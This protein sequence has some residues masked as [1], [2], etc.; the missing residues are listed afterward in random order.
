MRPDNRTR[1]PRLLSSLLVI[2]SILLLLVPTL[3]SKTI[4]HPATAQSGDSSPV[5]LPPPSLPPPPVPAAE[6]DFTYA[7]ERVVPEADRVEPIKL[8]AA[9]ELPAD[10]VERLLKRLPPFQQDDKPPAFTFPE[11]TLVK[12][13][14]SGKTIEEKFPPLEAPPKRKP[15][16]QSSAL[17]VLRVSQ[18]GAIDTAREFAITFSQPM[19]PVSDLD[20]VNAPEKLPVKFSPPTNGTWRWAGCQTLVFRPDNARKRFA[21]ATAYSVEIPKGT[22][23]AVGGVLEKTA[24]FSFTTAP[25]CLS[26]F[27]PNDGYQPHRLDQTMVL[28]FNQDIDQKEILKFINVTTSSG[29]GKAV[30]SRGSASQRSN[31]VLGK[32]KEGSAGDSSTL[33]EL[34]PVTEEI[35][36]KDDQIRSFIDSVKPSQWIAVKARKAFPIQSTVK[37][38]LLANCPSAEGPLK[39][40]SA[41]NFTFKTYGP[42]K[43]ISGPSKNVPADYAESKTFSFS[44]RIDKDKFKPSLVHVSPRIEDMKVVLYDYAPAIY[45]QGNTAIN[46]RYSV[47]FDKSICDVFGQQLGKDVVY[48]F[49]TGAMNPWLDVPEKPFMAIPA[50][51]P[52]EFS[53]N[54]AGIPKVQVKI[55]SV[56]PEDW[57]QF[58]PHTQS[59]NYYNF[60]SKA[61]DIGK[62]CQSKIIPVGPGQALIKLD[63]KPY[64]KDGTGQFVVSAKS[65]GTTR[66]DQRGFSEWVQVSNIGI[67]AYRG[68]KL[69]LMASSLGNG[70]PLKDARATV[71]PKGKS[72]LTDASGIASVDLDEQEKN[73]QALVVR[74]GTDC[75]ILPANLEWQPGWSALSKSPQLEWFAVTDR[76]LYRPGQTVKVKG[77][78]RGMQLGP[79]EQLQIFKSGADKLS[80]KVQASDSNE[81]K[82]GDAQLDDAGGFTF[83][84]DL[85]DH[86]SL[87]TATIQLCAQSAGARKFG[88]SSTMQTLEKYYNNL[89]T[90]Q[91]NFSVQEY[92]RP[93]FEMHL[94]SSSG[95]TLMLGEKT[96]IVADAKYFAGD[97]LQNAAISWVVQPSSTCYS[98]PGWSDFT[99]GDSPSWFLSCCSSFPGPPSLLSS[100]MAKQ[101]SGTTDASGKDS[102]DLRFISNKRHTPITCQCEATVTDV[103]RQ[104]WSDKLTLLVH[105]ASV[106]VGLKTSR[107]FYRKGEPISVDFVVTDLDGKAVAGRDVDLELRPVFDGLSPVGATGDADGSDQGGAPDAGGDKDNGIQKVDKKASARKSL[108]KHSLKSSERPLSVSFS[109]PGGGTYEVVAIV[110]DEQKRLS[111]SHA[112][113][114]VEQQLKKQ[115]RNVSEQKVLLMPDHQ[116][117]KP[118]DTAEITVSAPFAPAHGV[119]TIRKFGIASKT[120]ISSKSST[121][122]LKLP[123]TE[124]LSPGVN[125]EVDLVGER[126]SFASGSLAIEVPPSLKKLDLQ[127]VAKQQELAPNSD[128]TLSINLRGADGK[129]VAN[130][131]VAIAVVDEALLATAGYKWPDPIELFYPAQGDQVTSHHMRQFVVLS[132]KT[133]RVKPLVLGSRGYSHGGS[134]GG[135]ADLAALPPPS[136]LPPPPLPG[137]PAPQLQGATN[138]TIGPQGAD[139]DE[140][141]KSANDTPINLRKNFA[142][143]ALFAPAVTTGGDGTAEV[144][145]HLPDNLTRYRIMAA[146]AAGDDSFGSTESAVTARLPLMVKPS[147]PRFMN[148]GD[149]CELPVVLQNQTDRAMQ[150]SLVGRA[151]N[152]AFGQKNAWSVGEKPTA[153]QASNNCLGKILEVPAHDRVEV[154][155]PTAVS[156]TGNARFQFGAATDDGAADAAEVSFPVLKPA[157]FEA[158]AAYGQ[159]DKGAALQKIMPPADALPGTGELSVTMSST[160]V[161]S[162]T[163]AYFYLENY[164]FE[165]SEQLSSRVLAML[166]LQDVL[167]AFGKL[168][169][170][171]KEAFQAKVKHDIQILLS[172]QRGDGSFALW[173]LQEKQ[174]WPYVSL[175]VYRALKLAQQK[176]FAIPE[177]K[178][179]SAHNYIKS[180]DRVL[181]KR[182][183]K[184]CKR[185]LRAYALYLRYLEKDVDVDAA[186]AIV[187]EALADVARSHA[188]QSGQGA[189]ANLKEQMS[190]ETAA[191]LLPILSSKQTA[192]GKKIKDYIA[193]QIDET[194]STASLTSQGYSFFDYLLFYSSNREAAAVMDSLMLTDSKS[195]LIPKLAKGLMSGRKQGKWEGTQENAYVLIALSNYFSRYEGTAPEFDAQLWL[196]DKFAGSSQFV[197]RST[198]SHRLVIPVEA[199]KPSTNDL[200]INKSGAGRLYYRVAMDY[201]RKNLILPAADYGFSVNRTYEAVDD[202]QDVRKDSDGIWHFKAGSTVRVKIAFSCLGSRYHVA[203]ADPLAAGCEPVNP[204]LAGTRTLAPAPGQA[205]PW[206]VTP[207]VPNDTSD[208]SEIDDFPAAPWWTLAWY[209]QQNLRDHQ[210]EAFAPRIEAGNYTYTYNVRCTT[211]GMY[212]VPP[213]KA[214]EMYSSETFGRTRTERV[215]IE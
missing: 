16:A 132:E 148:V 103:N 179:G 32:D 57:P 194:A 73:A 82:K 13:P 190:V 158:F 93:E 149:S 176:G 7:V 156:T 118:G 44:N 143:L 70:S 126:S 4:V 172:R 140:F 100:P 78:L 116:K 72:A 129:P 46:T 154:R 53:F 206:G 185:S 48:Q 85:P 21:K 94:K 80:W 3:A 27:Y 59:Y 152:A 39:S 96:N 106:Y 139:K 205:V 163:D 177:E 56:K 207:S 49:T 181:D 12:P 142:E 79:S 40:S 168:S 159:I 169:G 150:V 23:S 86:V 6:S 63:L 113:L 178:L 31:A 191:W 66:Q 15:S 92:R 30:R 42:F 26:N 212:F 165:C 98:P 115:A 20:Q 138:G 161:Q 173:S 189:E 22:K 121:F 127:V 90:S 104:S 41:Q 204:D 196:D 34:T 164:K 111:E 102:I 87:G 210:A 83:S 195:D 35:A 8:A 135:S 60:S 153:V 75:A 62:T 201:V 134:G 200:L 167:G 47:T 64:L 162:L 54:A 208:T 166:S 125:I 29:N 2:W 145:L 114:F 197:G 122:S 198:D 187:N 61:L 84:F 137:S 199:L 101:L 11:Q 5:D 215:V 144:Q 130:G 151:A 182:M 170:K 91:I 117:Y 124:D 119:M 146:A 99:F 68:R 19:V 9:R 37:V 1:R 184:K 123:I 50:G 213:C 133:Q 36:K 25:V 38:K 74:H 45:I 88:Q 209:E 175:Q 77:W 174:R 18:Q 52:A 28:V 109:A 192:E 147:P 120:P 136:A 105:P 65:I 193:S 110:S 214:E 71:L 10:Q 188:K 89:V 180:I 17:T 24:K 51:G 157:S 203:L 211:P 202:K 128:T 183:D 171:E 14:V 160:A 108:E 141:G 131:Q 97:P 43:L 186:R 112:T 58:A 55:Q 33:Y 76:G 81:L 69:M 155:F 107:Y 67:D 95:T